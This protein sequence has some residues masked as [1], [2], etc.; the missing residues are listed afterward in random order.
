VTLTRLAR[1]I[2][3]L[4]VHSLFLFGSLYLGIGV[5]YNRG[6]GKEGADQLPHLEWWTVTLPGLVSDGCAFSLAKFQEFKEAKLKNGAGG[7]LGSSG[8]IDPDDPYRGKGAPTAR[9]DD[10]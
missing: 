2:L 4:S 9:S 7:L 5:L 1:A 8:E 10:L 3:L 6:Q